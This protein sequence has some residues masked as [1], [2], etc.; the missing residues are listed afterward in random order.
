MRE[1][2]F[3][4]WRSFKEDED[5]LS[6]EQLRCVLNAPVAVCLTMLDQLVKVLDPENENHLFLKESNL[7]EDNN[8]TYFNETL[9][10]R[11]NS[12]RNQLISWKEEPFVNAVD[13]NFVTSTYFALSS[14]GIDKTLHDSVNMQPI[15]VLDPFVWIISQVNPEMLEN[16][17]NIN[18]IAYPTHE[19]EDF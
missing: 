16:C 6:P 1:F 2:I 18:S 9:N 17:N 4:L 10:R 15:N 11:S 3:Y 5:E 14:R 12:L 7:I 19:D 13:Q 8:C